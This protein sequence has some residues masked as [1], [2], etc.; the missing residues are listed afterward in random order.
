M[1]AELVVILV[2]AAIGLC[3]IPVMFGTIIM[4]IRD[5]RRNPEQIGE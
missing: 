4:L 3:L 5:I 2:V 1:S